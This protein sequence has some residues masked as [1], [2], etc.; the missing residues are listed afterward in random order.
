[1][2][3]PRCF[4]RFENWSGGTVSH[5]RSSATSTGT[6]DTR[7]C[8]LFPST[9]RC[10]RRAQAG[11]GRTKRELQEIDAVIRIVSKRPLHSVSMHACHEPLTHIPEDLSVAMSLSAR[12]HSARA[13]AYSRHKRQ[14]RCHAFQ[15][16]DRRGRSCH[17][18]PARRACPLRRVSRQ[19]ALRFSGWP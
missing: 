18:Q 1:M 10:A 19:H 9:R 4:H 12:R 16:L 15:S 11:S 3:L 8:S 17:S 2:L 7:L 13:I 5:I 14:S 6:L